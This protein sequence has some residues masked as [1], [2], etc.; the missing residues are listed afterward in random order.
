MLERE[1]QRGLALEI[2]AHKVILMHAQLE[3]GRTSFFN[4]YWAKALC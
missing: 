4:H 3:C 2:T 1:W